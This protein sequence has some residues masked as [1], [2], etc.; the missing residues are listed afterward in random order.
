MACSRFPLKVL[1]KLL[2]KPAKV[3]SELPPKEAADACI[4]TAK[5]LLGHGH[6]REATLL[7]EGARTLDPK[8][9]ELSGFLAACYDRQNDAVKAKTEFDLALKLSPHDA[10]LCNDCG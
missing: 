6:D 2:T 5:H 7:F 9:T 8:R 10:V 3:Q 1:P 4:T